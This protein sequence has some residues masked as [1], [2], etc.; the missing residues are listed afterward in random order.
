MSYI[1]VVEDEDVLRELLEIVLSEE[2]YEVRSATD[3]RCALDLAACE[4]PS[5]I[6]FDLT[7]PD[8][9]GAA[10]VER[11]RAL[12]N[13]SAMLIA[14]SGI[15]NLAE[16]A[17]RIGVDAFLSKPFELAD[18]LSLVQRTLTLRRVG[19][20]AVMEP[21]CPTADAGYPGEQRDQA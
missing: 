9:S 20:Y 8:L 18:L 2:G 17:D 11:Y 6:L 21:R 14:V 15:A 4:R 16:E 19:E 1:L 7:L 13:A 5:L 12:P 3:A 10:F